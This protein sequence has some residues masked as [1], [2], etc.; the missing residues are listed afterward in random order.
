MQNV[1]GRTLVGLRFWNQARLFKFSS[2]VFVIQTCL[3][4]DDDGESY[5]VFES[6]DVRLCI[7][8]LSCC[9]FYYQPSRP[10]NP[11]DSRYILHRFSFACDNTCFSYRMFWVR[12]SSLDRF[13]FD[14]FLC[15][16]CA[17]C[18]PSFMG[19]TLD[20]IALETR[21]CVCTINLQCLQTLTNFS[22]FIPIVL[23]ALVFNVTNV[24]GFTYA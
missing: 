4:V 2:A 15:P 17:L 14:L 20:C 23:L 8:L 5:W 7:I 3:Q 18:V 11:V 19:S 21:F 10:A 12:P 16:D 13:I 6:R 9:L 22:S 24:I 1:S